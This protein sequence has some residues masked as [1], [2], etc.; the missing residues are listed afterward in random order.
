MTMSNLFG[1]LR[2]VLHAAALLAIVSCGGGGGGDVVDGGGQS[3]PIPHPPAIS[4]LSYSP[5]SA[6]ASPTDTATI[7]GTFNFTDAGGDVTAIRITTSAGADLTIPTASL[8]DVKT[9]TG[10]GSFTVSL[11]STGKVTF[12]VWV[13]DSRGD[14]SNKLTGAFE[15]LSPPQ[16]SHPPAISALT[17]D[18]GTALQAANGKATVN[19][20]INLTDSGGDV[21]F[22]RVTSTPAG[23]DT[24]IQAPLLAG[25]TSG[26]TTFSFNF[27]LDTVGTYP[28]EVWAIDSQG[29]ASNRL[30]GSFEVLAQTTTDTWSKLGVSPASPLFG[31]AWN[32]QRYVAVGEQGT[33]LTSDNLSAWSAQSSGVTHKLRSVAVSL[34]GYIAVGDGGDE[35]IILSSTDGVA[36]TVRYRSTVAA[37]LT[38]VIW[39][40]T[41]FVA[42][43]QEADAVAQKLYGLIL[44][45]PDG[46]AWTQR[47][48]RAMELGEF[49]NPP[50]PSMPAIAWS[51]SMFVTTGLDPDWNPAVWYSTN[52]DT[53]T[54]GTVP[55]AAVWATSWNDVVWGG[56]RFVAVSPVQDFGGHA[57][58]FTSV[59]GIGWQSDPGTPKLPPMRAVTYGANEYLAVS[60]THRE[61]SANGVE[62]TVS[63]ASD[64]GNAVLWDGTRYV[65]VGAS[66]CRSQ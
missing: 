56:G 19:G 29:G 30:F 36:W 64:C 1:S 39:A 10:A 52:L 6:L 54:L 35:A 9:G 51:G 46:T 58:V 25:V 7:N 38:K 65:S 43:G 14:S 3:N 12:E 16:T 41:Q 23:I 37:K 17:Y 13:T 11:A 4:N 18:P 47:A 2:A 59:D 45:S 63:A 33:V 66:I 44:T 8:K 31:I 15:V 22:V 48:A 57:P 49:G 34:N 27:S 55:T 60:N 28:F 40:G 24:T 21:V 26:A 62:W 50:V 53:W 61:K 5:L 32:G 42:V 20:T